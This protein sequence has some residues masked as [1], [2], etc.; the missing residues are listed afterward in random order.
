M[1]GPLPELAVHARRAVI[2]GTERGVSLAVQLG[3][4]VGIHDFGTDHRGAAAVDAAPTT[5]C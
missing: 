5:R 4:I 1:T 2:D 3:R